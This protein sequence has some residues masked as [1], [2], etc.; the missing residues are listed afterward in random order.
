M[1]LDGKR[2]RSRTGR[3]VAETRRPTAVDGPALLRPAASRHATG[4]GSGDGGRGWVRLQSQSAADAR[5][6]QDDRGTHMVGAT[7]PATNL[8][9]ARSRQALHAVD[10]ADRSDAWLYVL[11]A[12]RHD[13]I[14][15]PFDATQAKDSPSR[16]KIFACTPKTT[17]EETACARRIITRLATNGFR[18]PATAADINMLMEFYEFGRKEKDFDQGIE[19]VLARVLSSPQFI[20]RIEGSWL[21]AVRVRS[22]ASATSIWRRGCRSSSGAPRPTRSCS[23]RSRG[24]LE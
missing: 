19:M 22:T 18:R 1:L 24:T 4:A 3:A 9:Q 20:Y 14:E 23:S 13:Q 15:G 8:P 2:L 21:A 10:G 7:F 6:L 16:R 17:A 11:P 5:S 12:R